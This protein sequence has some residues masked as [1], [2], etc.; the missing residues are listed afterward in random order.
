MPRIPVACALLYRVIFRA[1]CIAVFSALATKQMKS[2]YDAINYGMGLERRGLLQNWLS[3]H[4]YR[5]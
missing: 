3:G 4:N 5:R 1:S 2:F